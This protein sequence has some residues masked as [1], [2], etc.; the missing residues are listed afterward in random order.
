L[1]EKPGKIPPKLRAIAL[2]DVFL[3]NDLRDLCILEKIGV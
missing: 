2:A 3:M 1:A